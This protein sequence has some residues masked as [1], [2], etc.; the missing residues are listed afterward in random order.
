MRKS[1]PDEASVCVDFRAHL[2]PRPI[3]RL[4]GPGAGCVPPLERR[5]PERPDFWFSVHLRD[6][7]NTKDEPM[8][9]RPKPAAELC[10]NWRF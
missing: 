3:D 2:S 7:N 6:L 9:N 5:R 1:E 8:V 10:A 4:V